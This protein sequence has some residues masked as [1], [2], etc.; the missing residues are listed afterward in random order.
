M[1]SMQC[2]KL[3][4]SY[5]CSSSESEPWG[6]QLAE[7]KP[8]PCHTRKLLSPPP[9]VKSQVHAQPQKPC[10][11]RSDPFGTRSAIYA[12]GASGSTR[13]FAHCTVFGN[14]T[15]WFQIPVQG[16]AQGVATMQD[17]SRLSD[18]TSGIPTPRCPTDRP[19]SVSD[20]LLCTRHASPAFPLLAPA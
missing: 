10:A 20:A 14:D 5:F 16:D 2:F 15:S 6:P 11:S 9:V 13:A 12:R 7:A 1:V 18:R 3:S 17:C 19:A 8:R 4:S